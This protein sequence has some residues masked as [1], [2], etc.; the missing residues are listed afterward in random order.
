MPSQAA[1][2]EA[3]G[4]TELPLL[5]TLV[6]MPRKAPDEDRAYRLDQ[7][8]QYTLQAQEDAYLFDLREPYFDEACA[9]YYHD[10]PHDAP[11][12]EPPAPQPCP[13]DSPWWPHTA[14][15]YTLAEA[16]F[17]NLPEGTWFHDPLSNLD[18]VKTGPS[19]AKTGTDSPFTYWFAQ[20]ERALTEAP[21]AQD[22]CAAQDA[23][24]LLA[25]QDYAPGSPAHS[26]CE[27]EN[28]AL[29]PTKENTK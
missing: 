14:Q 17:S 24:A 13:Q 25:E 26:L 12:Y 28:E 5:A 21:L 7:P 29:N 15:H 18:M 9:R 16:T 19:L 6:L 11:D 23:F 20:D 1:I 10:A 22:P 4:F 3:T 27:Q 8:R 2:Y